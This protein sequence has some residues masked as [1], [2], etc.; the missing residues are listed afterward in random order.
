VTAGRHPPERSPQLGDDGLGC[1][2]ATHEPEG[3]RL[4]DGERSEPIA[5]SP[6]HDQRDDPAVR[7][8]DQVRA[9]LDE[10]RELNGLVV[11]VDPIQRRVRRVAAAV[12]DDEPIA[13]GERPR[14]LPGA[15]ARRAVAVDQEDGRPGVPRALDVESHR[16][17]VAGGTGGRQTSNAGRG[18]SAVPRAGA[19][20]DPRGMNLR[21]SE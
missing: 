21:R 4:D 12:R 11:E 8:S 14:G 2:H 19:G 10:L 5:D 9:R 16:S 13:I 3:G 15:P 1:R 7:V 6:S 20:G 18:G 17:M